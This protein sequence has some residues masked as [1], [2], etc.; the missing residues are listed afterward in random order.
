MTNM[1]L[2]FITGGSSGIGQALAE[3]F[4]QQGWR[5]AL[6]ARRL[7]ELQNWSTEIT[8]QL[9]LTADR[10]GVFGAN[11]QD[12]DSI[13]AAAE[14][15]MAKMGLPNVVI[16]NAGISLGVDTTQREDLDMMRQVINTNVLG[17]HIS[18]FYTRH[19]RTGFRQL[20]RYR[21]RGWY[22][23]PTR[24]C[25]VLRQQG[26]RDQLLREFAR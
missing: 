2:V 6:T 13:I 16:A 19:A 1:R 22:T 14:Q 18:S 26:R 9:H 12:T 15:C 21:Q 4:L 20:G 8:Q 25:S 11:V 5:V 17:M 24:S 3:A 10:I 7:D 23:G